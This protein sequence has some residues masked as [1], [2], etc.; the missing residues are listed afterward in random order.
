MNVIQSNHLL[1]FLTPCFCCIKCLG[2]TKE[3]SFTVFI[4]KQIR[5][6]SIFLKHFEKRVGE[7]RV[8]DKVQIIL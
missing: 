8:N 7:R 4:K 6:K 3:E 5:I 1:V 2:I